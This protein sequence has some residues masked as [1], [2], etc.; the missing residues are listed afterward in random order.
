MAEIKQA[1]KS[2]GPVKWRIRHVINGLSEKQVREN[3]PEF[4]DFKPGISSTRIDSAS[5]TL[6]DG[7]KAH[8]GWILERVKPSE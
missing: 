8:C 6:K 2:F 3:F 4:E 1:A 7:T 5:I